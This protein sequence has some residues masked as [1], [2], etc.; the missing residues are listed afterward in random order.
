M[1]AP[2]QLRH[3]SAACAFAIATVA[4]GGPQTALDAT[5][6]AVLADR[7]DRLAD[8]LAADEACL[9]LEEADALVARAERG[10]AD[11]TVP[12]HVAAEI[13]AVAADVSG[14]LTCDPEPVT[15]PGADGASDDPEADTDEAE[16]GDDGGK[17][18]RGGKGPKGNPGRGGGPP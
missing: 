17:G 10:V 13:E 18:G 12:D 5:E 16:D 7:A 9:A 6:A 2:P 4:C 11:G 14:D 1:V 15:D 8:R 3:L